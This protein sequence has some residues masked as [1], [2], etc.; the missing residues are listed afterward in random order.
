MERRKVLLTN[1]SVP[2]RDQTVGWMERLN[3]FSNPPLG[4]LYLAGVLEREGHCVDVV[5]FA[6]SCMDQEAFIARLEAFEP[7][8]VGISCVTATY[9]FCAEIARLAR[10]V[11]PNALV[12]FG[13]PFPSFRYQ[14][15]LENTAADC[16]VRFEG[17]QTIL[18]LLA[19]LHNG[20]R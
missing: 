1:G 4:L 19:H 18:D 6:P 20:R 14:H 13:G 3:P 8:V 10:E 16:L 12:V 11:V 7:D 15:V 9:S 5:D 17:E 2:K